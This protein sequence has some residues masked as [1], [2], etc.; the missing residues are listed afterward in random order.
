MGI[1]FLLVLSAVAHNLRVDVQLGI[2]I[3][4]P[5]RQLSV[6]SAPFQG[7]ITHLGHLITLV[8][9]R[10]ECVQ[11]GLSILI[12]ILPRLVRVA[13]CLATSFLQVLLDL[14]PMP[15]SFVD[16][17]SRIMTVRVLLNVCLAIHSPGCIFLLDHRWDVRRVSVL[18][19]SLMRI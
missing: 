18:L 9:Q 4:I 10:H 19:A 2:L 16:L 5:T 14:A 17:D 8:V 13:Q 7:T 1:T 6:P 3:M 11:M 12:P 15:L